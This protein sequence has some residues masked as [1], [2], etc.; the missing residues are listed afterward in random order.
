MSETILERPAP[1]VALIRINRPEA[2]N[3]LDMPTRK[4]L[5]VHFRALSEDGETRCIVI[6]GGDKIFAAGAD[7]RELAEATP[8]EVMQRRTKELWAP[9]VACPIPVIAAVKGFALGG[10]CELSMHADIIVAGKSATFGQ[11]EVKV[12]VMPG[13][14]ATQ[15]LIRA[16]G[17]YKAMKMVLTGIPLSAEEAEKA[18]L[19][20][21]VVEDDAVLPRALELATLIAAMPP[22]AIAQIKEVMLAGADAPLH[23]GVALELRANQLLFASSD[24]KEGMRAFLEKR[25]PDFKGC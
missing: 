7:L 16:I 23:V 3:A 12:G 17:K 10:G 14:G 15:R 21:E 22:L 13:S 11:P 18:G 6:A 9:I 5:A 25:P 1:F 4:Q 19:V 20:S 8:I 24:Q 2:R